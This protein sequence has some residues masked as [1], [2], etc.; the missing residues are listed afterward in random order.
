MISKCF[1][2]PIY[3][4]N[5]TIKLKCF[6]PID[7]I[8]MLQCFISGIKT[9]DDQ[10][11]RSIK[12]PMT[13]MEFRNYLDSDGHMIKP[14][15]FRLSIYQ[16]GTEPSLRRVVWRHLLNIYPESMSGRERFAYMKKKENEYFELR[17][18]WRKL[19][20]THQ[21]SE[22]V[23]HVLSLVKKDVLRT[24]RT[25][26]HYAGGD[27]SKNLVA[28]YNLLVTFALTHPEVSYCQG[29][30]D[31]ASPILV[32]QKEEA[33]AY[34]CFC[35]LMKRLRTNFLYDGEAITTKLQHLSMLVN[36][37]DPEFHAYMKDHGA[38]DLFFCYRWLL[39]EMKREF[40]FDDALYMLEVMWSTLPPCPPETELALKDDSYCQS[41]L[42]SVSPNSPSFASKTQYSHLL[43]KRRLSHVMKESPLAKSPVARSPNSLSS[44]QNSLDNVTETSEKNVQLEDKV[45]ENTTVDDAV[46]DSKEQLSENKGTVED[47]VTLETD[48][49]DTSDT[50]D[51]IGEETSENEK[52][53][54][55]DTSETVK[56]SN[57]INENDS[58]ASAN[59]AT[60]NK[61]SSDYNSAVE[62]LTNTSPSTSVITNC[63]SYLS[64]SQS[65]ERFP[66]LISASLNEDTHVLSFNGGQTLTN[67]VSNQECT[68]K[69]CSSSNNEHTRISKDNGL[70]DNKK[71][72]SSQSIGDFDDENDNQA[73]FY[74]SM[75]ETEPARDIKAETPKKSDVP[76]IKGSFFSG[77]K[78]LLKSPER[79][80][81]KAP[82]SMDDSKQGVPKSSSLG[83]I[84]ST[85]GKVANSSSSESNDNDSEHTLFEVNRMF[86]SLNV[87][88]LSSLESDSGNGSL[89]SSNGNCLT[90]K[91]RSNSQLKG[92]GLASRS[93]DGLSEEQKHYF[94]KKFKEVL[95]QVPTP[96]AMLGGKQPLFCD[97]HFALDGLDTARMEESKDSGE[98]DEI[99]DCTEAVDPEELELTRFK[100]LPP[101]DEFGYGNPFLMFACLTVLL[102][103]RDIIMK[104][105]MEY[106]ELA[107]YFDKM[108]RKHN[109]NKVLH[110]A[111]ILYTEYIRMQQKIQTETY[112]DEDVQFSL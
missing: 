42:V 108:V 109:V 23:K 97:N 49:V 62:S 45:L 17:D 4:I 103:H 76:K 60:H 1:L 80:Q 78:K 66:S 72:S 10:E 8:L 98:K 44:N 67:S 81:G 14:G 13:D 12:A 91:Q 43:A 36:F 9:E 50:V 15:E 3:P 34:L 82:H 61:S 41:L 57:G 79:K 85:C 71:V 47:L 48:N 54:N 51:G 74:M 26:K 16:G 102:Q 93:F 46:N 94:D 104:T 6:L 69:K 33:Q 87:E 35:G 111:R 38:D 7:G 22:E 107:M 59:T 63:S 83:N 75:E 105:G 96:E 64:S 56:E 18:Q 101:P 106:D 70:V 24:D 19:Q 58:H 112:Q 65:A 27:E 99:S 100:Q 30:S 37:Y 89:T 86:K 25:H 29:M 95:R 52:Q 110:Q 32:V 21:L 2:I 39:L 55:A 5:Y 53:N 20:T 40:P 11:Y 28:L 84:A 73:Q 77:M 31:I 88:V 68:I 90:G 92:H